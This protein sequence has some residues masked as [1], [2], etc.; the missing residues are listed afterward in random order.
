V[1]PERREE[2]WARL[3]AIFPAYED[4]QR[5]AGRDFPVV[6]FAPTGQDKAEDVDAGLEVMSD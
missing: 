4:H 6:A 3:T 1:E 5:T 2:L